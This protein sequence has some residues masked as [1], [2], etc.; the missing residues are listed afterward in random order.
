MKRPLEFARSLLAVFLVTGPAAAQFGPPPVV[1]P[2]KYDS[3]SGEYVLDVD[4]SHMQGS[5]AAT[6]RLTHQ[7]RQ[8]WS[9]ERPFTL[10]DARVTDGGVVAGY[11]YSSGLEGFG[12]DDKLHLLILGRT[13]A[14][15]LNDTTPRRQSLVVDGGPEPNVDGLVFDP[16]GDRIVFRVSNVGGPE[17]W[18]PFQLSS[19]HAA[20]PFEPASLMAVGEL[21]VSAVDAQPARGTPLTL[22][23]W[24]R[25]DWHKEQQ[26]A[27]FSLV[28]PMGHPV[29]MLELPTDYLAAPGD[30]KGQE[31]LSR[32]AWKTAIIDVSR[33]NELV[34]RHAATSERVRY[35]IE[36]NASAGWVVGETGR[37]PD[38]DGPA[39]ESADVVVGPERSLRYIG[40]VKLGGRTDEENGAIRDV[41][42]FD[43]D[44]GGRYGFVRRDG[45][46]ELTFVT[47]ARNDPPRQ[48]RLGRPGRQECSSPLVAWAG[49]NT[50]IV[51][52]E[53]AKAESGE[54]GWWVDRDNGAT[55]PFILPAG[56]SS[57]R[58]IAG[59]RT[60]GIVLLA[61]QETRSALMVEIDTLLVW[62]DVLGHEQKALSDSANSS[63]SELL[64]PDDVAVTT[65]GEVVVVDVVRHKVTVF[66][67][68]GSLQRTIDLEKAWGREPNYPSGIA[69]DADGGFIVED[70]NAAIPF[71]RMRADG[72]V[73]GELRPRYADG[74]PTGRL[75]R[76]QAGPDGVLWASDGEALLH[77]REDGVV[78]G[79]VG[80]Q[81][82]LDDLGEAAAVAIDA[83]DNVYAA[84]RRSGAVH[85]FSA[86]G[87]LEHVCRPRP[88]DVKDSL[89][90]PTMTTTSDGRVFLRLD[91]GI[92]SGGGF[93]EF[94]AAGDRIARH[95]WE[96]RSRLWNPATGGFWAVRHNNIAAITEKGQVAMTI[97]RRA[98]RRWLGWISGAAVA[99]DGSIAVAAEADQLRSERNDA[100]LNV[101]SS[102]GSATHVIQLSPGRSGAPFA[103]DGRA[104]ALW[105]AGEVRILDLAGQPVARFRPRPAGQ[106]ALDWPLLFAAQG[107]ELWMFDSATKTMHR[108][109]LP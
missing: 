40:A 81:A 27:R 75:F 17:I 44:D 25:N 95:A 7:G 8:V 77:L 14:P 47:A 55:R 51:T 71:V 89:V 79:V 38:V 37:Q 70:F 59:R 46:C 80:T 103:Y 23:H 94:S 67:A 62:I 82:S 60:G 96:D 56:I 74:R 76:V 5:G 68:D 48:I 106:E 31:R 41:H 64:S 90:W 87:K 33:P 50:W 24:S 83:G 73:R 104:I 61:E 108:F 39:A 36:K 42:H 35:Q 92:R 66:E 69:P 98:D 52:T 105:Q 100:T 1:D 54:A 72:A 29:W 45:S 86:Q 11:A 32:L 58:A 2:A 9:G 49:G 107:R 12:D 10:L 109:E 78:E 99:E 85:V 97:A 20:A 26:G 15:L 65:A 102:N 13:G 3:P 16:D 18:K 6:Y 84:D 53:Y 28:D 91:D 63:D 19:G 4:P 30:R 21:S 22:I 43:L 57:V 93:L 88:G 101:Y 34:V